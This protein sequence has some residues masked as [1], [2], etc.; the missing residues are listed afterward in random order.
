MYITESEY[1]CFTLRF[2]EK[3]FF[4]S[5]ANTSACELRVNDQSVDTL[6]KLTI[7]KFFGF[8]AK[9]VPEIPDRRVSRI[10]DILFARNTARSSTMQH[11]KQPTPIADC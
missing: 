9:F 4:L 5:F 10:V 7:V 6:L 11:K 3:N 8:K 2:M 1:L